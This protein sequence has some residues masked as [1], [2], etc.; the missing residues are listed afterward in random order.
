M[1]I[2]QLVEIDKK[3]FRVDVGNYTYYILLKQGRF[4][5]SGVAIAKYDYIEKTL[6]I[7]K[8]NKYNAKI[9]KYINKLKQYFNNRGYSI[10]IKEDTVVVA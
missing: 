3:L 4:Y 2:R 9:A 8:Y 7:D 10:K 6:W 5:K 1:Y